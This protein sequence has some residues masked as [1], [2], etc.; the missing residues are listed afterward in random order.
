MARGTSGTISLWATWNTRAAAGV[1]C[2][3]SRAAASA[4]YDFLFHGVRNESRRRVLAKIKSCYRRLRVD[5][6]PEFCVDIGFCFGLLDPASNILVNATVSVGASHVKRGGGNHQFALEGMHRRSLDGLVAFLTRLFPYLPGAEALRYLAVAGADPVVASLLVIKRRGA[7]RSFRTD[8]SGVTAAAVEAALVC[9]A[10]AAGH[11]DPRRLVLA[12]KHLSP[13]LSSPP[14]YHRPTLGKRLEESWGVASSRLVTV[15]A[16]SQARLPPARG[17]VKRMLL[18]TIHGFHLQALARLPTAELQSRLHRSVLEGGHCYGPLDPVSNIIVNTVRHHQAFPTSKEV[19]LRMIST[20]TL[21]RVAARSLYGLVSFLCTRYPGLTPDLA[22]QRLHAAGADLRVADPNLDA[23][24]RNDRTLPRR[25]W[26]AAGCSSGCGSAGLD[27]AYTAAATAARHPNPVAQ[28]ELLGSPDAVAKLKDAS[29][30]LPRDGRRRLSSEDLELLSRSLLECR[31]P[32]LGDSQQQQEA[33]PRKLNKG[34]YAL[35]DFLSNSFWDNQEKL[36]SRVE[37]ALDEYN[38]QP[39]VPE[40][41]LHVICSVNERVTGTGP[42][43]TAG[44]EGFRNN[45]SHINFLATCKDSQ[46]PAV[47]FFAECSNHVNGT[48]KVSLCRPDSLT[49]PGAEQVRCI[50][51][52]RECA[53]LVHPAVE[54]FNGRDREFEKAARGV[55]DVSSWW[56]KTGYNDQIITDNSFESDWVDLV[57]DDFICPT[58][59]A[60]EDG[61]EEP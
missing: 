25:W 46:S 44:V 15:S 20:K 4:A 28:R 55:P 56:D 32:S 33:A 22:L 36:S 37:A 45:Y 2:P 21:N 52:E 23:T 12:W 30:K 38:R 7:E 9:A 54:S 14:G 16:R 26:S 6:A 24:E 27:E 29:S 39:G 40:Y 48:V 3:R 17:A 13:C 8:G 19:T 60:A 34:E 31:C 51:C 50:Y 58:D 11:P 49:L 41:R 18:A 43:F 47:L 61:E 59:Y 35:V 42:G 5:V 53:R 10:V 57:H 1:F